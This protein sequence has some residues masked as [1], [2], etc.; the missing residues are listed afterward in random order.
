MRLGSAGTAILQ[1]LDGDTADI[2][3]EAATHAQGQFGLH[4]ITELV[5]RTSGSLQ[6]LNSPHPSA[7]IGGTITTGVVKH[8]VLQ[9]DETLNDAS[10][11]LTVPVDTI[12]HVLW[13]HV[14]YVSTATAGNRH[15]RFTYRDAADDVIGRSD[16]GVLQAASTTVVYNFLPGVARE[17]TVVE[18][19]LLTPIPTGLWL[20][21]GFDMT[22]VDINSVD[23]TADD[24][25]VQMQV[26]EFAT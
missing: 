6:A 26:E 18:G 2:L 23:L 14:E 21:A 22:I 15:L 20:P 24:M 7:F 19:Q 16:T 4:T 9:I 17:T 10:K 12:W 5:V 3:V 11:I 1:D 13:L 8:T 25:V